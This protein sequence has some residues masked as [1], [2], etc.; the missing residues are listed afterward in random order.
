MGATRN[1]TFVPGAS[2]HRQTLDVG[3]VLELGSIESLTDSHDVHYGALDIN[4]VW[5]QIRSR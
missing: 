5:A 4:T 3:I 1:C 2:T